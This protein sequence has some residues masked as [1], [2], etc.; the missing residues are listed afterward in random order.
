M[1][2][3]PN[4]GTSDTTSTAVQMTED[5]VAHY[6]TQYLHLRVDQINDSEIPLQ[7]TRDARILSLAQFFHAYEI[8][9]QEGHSRSNLPPWQTIPR[10]E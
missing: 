2:T 7:D 5:E 6:R 1:E 8:D 3:S 9:H 4:V 10:H